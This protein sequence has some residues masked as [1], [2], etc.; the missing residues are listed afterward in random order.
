M[1]VSFYNN[2][3]DL[4]KESFSAGP[5]Y[6]TNDVGTT[7]FIWVKAGDVEKTILAARPKSVKEKED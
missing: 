5:Y 2:Y 6:Q 3:N 1:E 4:V 7:Y